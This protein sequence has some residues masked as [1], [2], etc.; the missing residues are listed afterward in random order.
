MLF[1]V[2]LNVSCEKVIDLKLNT[3]P[4]RLVVD[5]AL[6]WVKGT[7]GKNQSVILSTTTNYFNNEI[8]KVSGATVY[9]TNSSNN[10][11]DFLEEPN[12]KGKY[13]CINFVPLI[14]ETYV[15][16]IIYDGET[17]KG[18]EKLMPVNPIESVEQRSD[19]GLNRD[20]FGIKVYFK[21]TP[22]QKDFFVLSYVTPSLAFPSIEVTN[23][24]FF[25][26]RTTFG[27]FGSDK[28]KQNDIINIRLN[29][30][31]ERYFNYYRKLTSTANGGG[32]GPFQPSPSSTIRGNLVNQTNESNY[33][34]GYFSISETSKI[35]YTIK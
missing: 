2:F 8:P 33:C 11:F 10:R 29:G 30:I 21:D 31:S 1:A 19:L 14:N 34:L 15:L 5:A 24:M 23:D 32:G 6:N 27:L 35:T 3:E 17:Y 18:Q 20:E 25:E 7:D 16:T 12:I 4:P 13:T 22:D 9:A 26:G 28:L